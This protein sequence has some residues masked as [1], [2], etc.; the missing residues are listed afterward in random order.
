VNTGITLWERYFNS[1]KGPPKILLPSLKV[2]SNFQRLGIWI[3]SQQHT[4]TPKIYTVSFGGITVGGVGKTPAVIERAEREI[5]VNSKRVC[6]ISRGYGSKKSHAIVEGIYKEGKVLTRFYSSEKELNPFEEKTLSWGE[7]CKVL[8]DELT[9]ILYR[10]PEV[11]VIKNPNRVHAVNWA[12]CRNFDV[13]I[14]DDAYQYLM[15]ARNENIL[16]LSALNPWG[17]RLIFPAGILR[18]PLNAMSRATEIWVSHC[19]QV[20]KEKLETLK[21][22]FEQNY[23]DKKTRWTYHKSLFWRKHNTNQTLPLDSFKNKEAD[24]YCAIGNPDSFLNTLKNLQVCVKNVY[25]YRDH[26]P[27]PKAMMKEERIVLT[28]EK[29]MLTL[30]E[31]NVEVYALYIGLSDYSWD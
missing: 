25:V 4:Y 17:N 22:F 23:P 9:L 6:V 13:I 21:N 18:E 14:L 2:L 5:N 7:A 26:T 10:L 28:T 3:R 24:I 20:P 11:T 15:L 19:D 16:L 31:A 27:I 30:E 12:E 29:N 8:G 1:A